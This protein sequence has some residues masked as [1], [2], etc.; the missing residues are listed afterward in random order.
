MCIEHACCSGVDKRSNLTA[1]E[2]GANMILAPL[3]CGVRRD[4]LHPGTYRMER[5]L[6]KPT[7]PEA[8]SVNYS[9]AATCA[10]EGRVEA[11]SYTLIRCFPST[12]PRLTCGIGDKGQPR[13]WAIF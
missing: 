6:L 8:R 1:A 11:C 9:T 2:V 4:S 7:S 12:R 10:L 3:Q 5:A 13:F